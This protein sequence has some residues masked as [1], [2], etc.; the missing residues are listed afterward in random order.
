MFSF[1][2]GGFQIIG[3]PRFLLYLF[4]KSTGELSDET[5]RPASSI[6]GLVDLAARSWGTGVLH[7]SSIEETSSV[8]GLSSTIS[9]DLLHSRKP[10][11]NIVA[12]RRSFK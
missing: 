5:I 6:A 9:E 10:A 1:V 7:R 8:K 3:H 2:K 12:A 11:D 4:W